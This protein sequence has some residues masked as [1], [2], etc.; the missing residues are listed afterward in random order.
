MAARSRTQ[1]AK[2]CGLLRRK[3]LWFFGCVKLNMVERREATMLNS[4]AE[5]T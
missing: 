1:N 3:Q 5:G 2:N 4:E